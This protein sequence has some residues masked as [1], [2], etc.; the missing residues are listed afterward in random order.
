MP[1]TSSG[2]GSVFS[3]KT[4]S[5]FDRLRHRSLWMFDFYINL[6]EKKPFMYIEKLF[7]HVWRIG[8]PE[9]VE[10][11]F[12]LMEMRHTV[13]ELAEG[14]GTRMIFTDKFDAD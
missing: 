10:G 8:V 11:T 12:I 9:P 13:P 7:T 14:S 4:T 2:T 6:S 1:S 5:A 3:K